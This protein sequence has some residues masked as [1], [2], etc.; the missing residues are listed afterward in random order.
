MKK[1]KQVA[2]IAAVLGTV[3]LAPLSASA[4]EIAETV[5]TYQTNGVVKFVPSTEPSKPMDPTD[6]G[7]KQPVKPVDPTTKDGE[8]NE[9]TSGPLSIDYASS[10]DFGVNQIANNDITYYANA[11]EV[12]SESDSKYT[13]NYVQITDNRGTNAGW[14]LK[15]KQ[16]GQFSNDTALHKELTG[17]QIQFVDPT[18][19]SNSTAKAPTPANVIKLDPNGAESLVMSAKSTEGAGIWIDRWGTAEEMTNDQGEKVQKNKA[20]SLSIPGGTP[21]DAVQYSTKLT[22]SLSDTPGN[23]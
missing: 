11:Q 9:G 18:I 14:T 7:S 22:W 8:P 12:R 21:K 1:T 4:E 5:K 13:P 10:L 19:V 6:P 20:I 23:E 17:A 15:V 2:A 3:A 16:G